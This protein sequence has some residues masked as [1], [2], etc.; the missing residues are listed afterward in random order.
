MKFNMSLIAKKLPIIIYPNKILRKNSVNI[1]NILSESIQQLII[2]MKL[3]MQAANGIGLAAPQIGQNINLIVVDDGQG[4][5]ILINPTII[6]KSYNK[7]I[8]EEGCL[9]IPDV[10]GPVTRPEKVWLIYRDENNKFN[11]KISS[12][13]EARII[14]HEVDHLRGILFID[15]TST[16]TQGKEKLE[17]YEN[18]VK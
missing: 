4:P 14:Q 8:F 9:S 5:K 15:K 1:K 11:F 17:L 18:N 3:T 7:N 16:I 13:L 10:F 12:G 2:D 6:F